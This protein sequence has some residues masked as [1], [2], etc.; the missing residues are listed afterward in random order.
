MFLRVSIELLIAA[1]FVALFAWKVIIPIYQNIR[2]KQLQEVENVEAHLKEVEVE[3]KKL[4]VEEKAVEIEIAN[5]QKKESIER[6]RS[7]RS[8]KP[9]QPIKTNKKGK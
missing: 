1:A 9:A 8:V 4:E 7:T 2:R 5:E 6:K 3:A